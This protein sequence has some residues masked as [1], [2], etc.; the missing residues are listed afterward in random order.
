MVRLWMCWEAKMVT[1][2]GRL[3]VGYE[4]NRVQGDIKVCGLS[5]RKGRIDVPWG[6][7]KSKGAGAGWEGSGSLGCA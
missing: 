1:S 2:A 3:D 5:D 6:G 4:K 7:A